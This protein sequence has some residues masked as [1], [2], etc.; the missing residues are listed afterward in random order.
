MQTANQKTLQIFSCFFLKQ[1]SL[2]K[3]YSSIICSS[4]SSS[5]SSPS[6]INLIVLFYFDHLSQLVVEFSDDTFSI[7]ETFPN[8][9]LMHIS[10]SLVHWFANF[11][12]YLVTRQMS[13]H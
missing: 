6:S 3:S 12:N 10:Q 4:S 9:E 8:E 5:S 13:S 11:V 1:K 2:S 7:S